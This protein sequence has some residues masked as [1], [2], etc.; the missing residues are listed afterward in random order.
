MDASAEKSST[1]LPTAQELMEKLA[2]AEAEKA[3]QAARKH[4]AAEAEKKALL[5]KLTTPS[6]VSDEEALKRVAI[7]VERAVANGLT[8]VQV[9]RFPNSLCTDHGRAINQ[10]EPGWESTLTG[11]PKEMYEFWDRQLRPLG[12]KLRVRIVDFPGGMPGDVGITLKWA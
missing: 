3:S 10:Q 2:L 4:A 8:E 9:Y 7:I 11:L 5:D 12:Y 1:G 6:G